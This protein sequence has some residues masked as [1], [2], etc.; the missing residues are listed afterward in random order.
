MQVKIEV[1]AQ[2][3]ENYNVDGEGFNNCGD[4]KPYWKPKG[5]Q[6]FIFPVDSD[7]AMYVN[8]EEMIEAIDQMLAN[9]SDIGSKYEY[10]DHEVVFGDSIVLEGLQEIRAEIFG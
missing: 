7:W 4:K 6:E 10:R 5:G 1:Q 2:Y 8:K 9:Y 3:L